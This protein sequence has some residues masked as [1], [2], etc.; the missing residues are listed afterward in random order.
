[1]AKGYWIAAYQSISDPGKL[2]DYGKL[3]GPA[4]EA[5]GGRFLARGGQVTAHEA[6]TAER[7][8]VIEFDSYAQAEAAYQ[9]EPYQ[10]A[11]AVLDGAAVRDIRIVE[12][13]D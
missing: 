12:G 3:A 5:A 9:S 1:M 8:V 4:I 13:V 6:G 11:L 7:T 10:R 2:A